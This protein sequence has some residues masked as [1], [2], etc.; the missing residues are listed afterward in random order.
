MPHST[1]PLPLSSR[2]REDGNFAPRVKPAYKERT[3]PLRAAGT[4]SGAWLGPGSLGHVGQGPPGA[5]QTSASTLVRVD[6]GSQKQRGNPI[7]PGQQ[8]TRAA[9]LRTGPTGRGEEGAASRSGCWLQLRG[10]HARHWV[11]RHQDQQTA[12]HHADRQVHQLGH[13]TALPAARMAAAQLSASS[14][15]YLLTPTGS[16]SQSQDLGCCKGLSPNLG[17]RTPPSSCSGDTGDSTRAPGWKGI[18]GGL[19]WGN[20]E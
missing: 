19:F 6:A 16:G 5:A 3:E 20:L 14:S 7:Y 17:C 4:G 8:G 1:Q 10:S 9:Q 13:S 15:A 2:C 12:Q 18:G 11:A